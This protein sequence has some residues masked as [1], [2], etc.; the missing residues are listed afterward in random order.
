MPD[1]IVLDVLFGVPAVVTPAG[2]QPEKWADGLTGNAERINDRRNEKLPDDGTFNALVADPSSSSYSPM[3]DA[4]FITKKG[5]TAPQI[6]RRQYK[7]L[8]GSFAAYSR[9]L[10]LAFATVDGVIAKRFKDQVVNS[11]DAWAEAVALKTL[12]ITGDKI[13]GRFISQAAYWLT[14]DYKANR[15]TNE[16]QLIAGAPYNILGVGGLLSQFKAALMGLLTQGATNIFDAD[17][18]AEAIEDENDRL[19]TLANGFASVLVK[20]FAAGG[21]PTDSLLEWVYLDPLFKL[22]ARVVLV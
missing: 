1:V 3:L 15:M 4:T 19:E 17:F 5:L 18:L 11:K 10:D 21:G 13:R 16:V 9:K 6:I 22:H 7:N 20:P 14:G 12:R 8:S 2:D